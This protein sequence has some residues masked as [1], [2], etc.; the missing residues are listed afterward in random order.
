MADFYS[1]ADQDYDLNIMD[2]CLTSRERDLP[3]PL[4]I[5]F[6]HDFILFLNHLKEH[7]IQKTKTGSI[8]IKPILPLLN[9]FKDNR[10][11]LEIRKMGWELHREDEYNALLQIKIIALN[12]YIIYNRKEYLYL[13]KNGRGYLDKVDPLAQYSAMVLH[14]WY[15][16]N[17]DYIS[18]THPCG[19]SNFGEII[20][21]NQNELW[22]ILLKEKDKWLDFESFANTLISYL[23]LN[24]YFKNTYDPHEDSQFSIN[25][26]VYFD[27]FA[28]NLLRFGIVEF[29]PF[30]PK[31]TWQDLP[32][33][34]NARFRLTPM[35]IYILEQ[36]LFHNYL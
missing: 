36:A 26:A 24:D 17:W 31:S 3:D 19:K 13:S 10:H 9:Q 2:S 15:R 8:S 25:L 34:N 1:Q 20:Y 22:Q 33:Q 32:Y 18:P 30:T 5:P 23:H 7:P 16:T 27:L 35:G 29:E 28:H 11:L 21:Q 14:Y 6:F 4:T 12:M